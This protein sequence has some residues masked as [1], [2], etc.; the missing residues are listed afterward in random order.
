MN[1][2]GYFND[3]VKN[4]IVDVLTKIKEVNQINPV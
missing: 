4:K 3:E 2:S 1:A